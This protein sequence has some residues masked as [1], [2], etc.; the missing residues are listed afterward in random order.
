M[1]DPFAGQTSHRIDRLVS[2]GVSRG[3][4]SAVFSISDWS[5][6]SRSQCSRSTSSVVAVFTRTPG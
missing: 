2:R 3:A 1:V 4:G 5:R 6:P